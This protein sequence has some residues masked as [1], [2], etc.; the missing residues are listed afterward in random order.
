[1]INLL[2]TSAIFLDIDGVLNQYNHHER[3]R[4]HNIHKASGFK[5]ELDTFNPAK[6][7]IQQLSAVVN[8]YNVDVY[9]FSAWSS[10]RLQPFLPFTLKGDTI[11]RMTNVIDLMVKYKQNILIEDEYKTEL[12]GKDR[13]PLPK[14]LT[15]MKI[16]G[17]FGMVKKDYTKLNRLLKG[18]K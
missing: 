11:K 4:R 8:R 13:L 14:G 17:D 10:E 3:K 5:E 18:V 7:K 15:L 1:M 9:V 16:N 12:F 6:K 2:G